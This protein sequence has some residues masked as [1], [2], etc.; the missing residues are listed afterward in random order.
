MISPTNKEILEKLNKDECVVDWVP[1]PYTYRYIGDEEK[2]YY[3]C[4]KCK[5]NLSKNKDEYL[6][7]EKL[8]IALWHPECKS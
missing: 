4:Y 7:H 3:W 2:W 6:K 1:C 5:I 8:I